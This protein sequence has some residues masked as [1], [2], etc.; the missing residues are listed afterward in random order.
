MPYFWVTMEALI[1]FWAPC[2]DLAPWPVIPSAP[3]SVWT[4]PSDFAVS[5]QSSQFT[6]VYE[7]ASTSWNVWSG[8][9]EQAAVSALTAVGQALEAALQALVAFVEKEVIKLLTP[10]FQPILTS[11][12]Q[13]EKSLSSDVLNA[14]ADLNN[15]DSITAAAAQF[16]QDASGPV[17]FLAAGLGTT[18]SIATTVLEVLSL[19]VGFFI[20]IV[21]GLVLTGGAAATAGKGGLLNSLLSEFKSLNPSNALSGVL[22]EWESIF[23]GQSQVVSQAPPS[24]KVRPSVSH[25]LEQTLAGILSIATSSAAASEVIDAVIVSKNPEPLKFGAAFFGFLGMFVASAAAYFSDAAGAWV[26]L[27]FIGWSIFMDLVYIVEVEADLGS[28]LTIGLD[29]MAFVLDACSLGLV[30]YC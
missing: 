5:W 20:P 28:L 6:P 7:W 23:N 10:V 15:G 29:G 19:G 22:G 1:R 8:V 21:I 4:T 27:A 14:Q 2:D 17:F 13:Y 18:L 11:I 9:A 3:P 16:W 24:A 26:S 25:S 30:S 12:N